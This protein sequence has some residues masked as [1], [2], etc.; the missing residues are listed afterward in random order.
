MRADSGVELRIA[1]CV[2]QPGSDLSADKVNQQ[3]LRLVDRLSAQPDGSIGFE[4][5][6]PANEIPTVTYSL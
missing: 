6:Q 4:V 1:A 2:M 3:L 5:E